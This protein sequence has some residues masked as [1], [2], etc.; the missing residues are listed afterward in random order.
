MR[1][2]TLAQ[3]LKDHGYA[4]SFVSAEVSGNLAAKIRE[5]GIDC[6]LIEAVAW[7]EDAKLT[8]EIIGNKRVNWLIVDNYQLDY[9]WHQALRK[10]VDKILVID[11][12]AN[13]MLDCDLLLDTGLGKTEADYRGLLPENCRKL[14]GADYALVRKEFILNRAESEEKRKN[15]KNISRILI[16]FGA[17]DPHNLIPALLESLP[18]KF[19]HIEFDI[20]VA[21]STANLLTIRKMCEKKQNCHLFVDVASMADHMLKADLAIGAGGSTAYE[22]CAVGLP[23]IVLSIA[24]NQDHFVEALKNRKAIEKLDIK[25]DFI[26]KISDKIR[27]YQEDHAKLKAMSRNAFAVISMNGALK[28][29]KAMEKYYEL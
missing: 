2:L 21:S 28:V 16:N 5:Y 6:C 14:I 20:V 1:C 11:D 27:L 7:Q 4:V 12:L 29:V 24:K 13:R 26:Q 17:N 25:T 8:A 9:H 3:A 23:S 15:L 19:T 22:R 18:E 10:K